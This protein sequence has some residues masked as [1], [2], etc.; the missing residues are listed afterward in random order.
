MNQYFRDFHNNWIAKANAISTNE[1]SDIFDKYITLFVIYNNL[2]NQVPNKLIISGIPVPNKIF[3]NKAATELVVKF[4][5][6]EDLLLEFSNNNLDN[7]IESIINLIDQ[8]TFHIKINYGGYN[9][10]EDL[11]ILNELKSENK[12]KK[13]TGILKV[14]YYVRC[15]IFHGNK[16]FVEYQRILMEPLIKILSVTNDF[17]FRKLTE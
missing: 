17:L 3:D 16:D 14:I 6:P 5:T 4:L 1:L 11:K 7:D 12:G 15:N 10:N 8:E 2:Y 13:A 9:R